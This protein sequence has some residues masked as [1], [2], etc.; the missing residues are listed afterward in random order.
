MT[1]DLAGKKFHRLTAISY[2]T[3]SKWLCLCDCGN[4]INVRTRDLNTN[5]TK[6]CGC[7]KREVLSSTEQKDKLISYSTK[8]HPRISSARRVWRDYTNRFKNIICITFE[9]FLEKS[10]MNCYYCGI[11]P[12]N[13]INTFIYQKSIQYNI[14][15]GDFI[16]SGLDRINSDRYY[17]E[18]NIVPCCIA[19]NRAKSD[20]SMDE[21][22][23]WVDKLNCSQEKPI[24]IKKSLS[25]NKS[26]NASIK[27][28]FKKYKK[29]TDMTIE[30]FYWTSQ[31]KC[32]Y[33]GENPSNCNNAAKA[34][35]KS[36]QHAK[37]TGD[38]I[39]NGLDRID[40]KLNHNKNNVVPSCIKCNWAKGNKDLEEFQKWIQRI[41][42][43]QKDRIK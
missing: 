19:C 13:K 6:S 37:E 34:D 15:N 4:Y 42:A 36:S 17:T 20:Y 43:F 1:H 28:V 10:Q 11:F 38:F 9:I 21:F 41:Q 12:Q 5:N 27:R 26:L 33:C 30:E 8:Y 31:Q 2:I 18:D 22:L 7:L 39:Y 35:K 3:G 25:T 16:Y 24:I 14:D 40:S 29:D 32:I 23:L